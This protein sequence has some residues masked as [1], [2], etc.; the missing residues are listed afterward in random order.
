MFPLHCNSCFC[1]QKFEPNR[2]FHVSRCG[3]I[4]CK[5]CLQPNCP[6]CSKPY[7]AIEI[8]KDM[9]PAMVQYFDDP[10]KHYRHYQNIM[11]FHY[12]Q[13]AML[14][15]HMTTS[16]DAQIKKLEGE[17]KAFARIQ[18]TLDDKL[19]Q[20]RNRIRKLKEYIA[21]HE[22]R[23]EMAPPT[24][25][26]ITAQP[27]FRYPSSR[28]KTSSDEGKSKSR[29]CLDFMPQLT[30]TIRAHYAPPRSPTLSNPNSS[31][32]E[33]TIGHSS[34]NKMRSQPSP[35]PPMTEHK[36]KSKADVSYL[37]F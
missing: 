11:K 5:E 21:Y 15:D 19:E 9:P 35:L 7:N 29:E 20:E 1:R 28:H 10:I 37:K 26:S 31:E 32:S 36:K 34:L 25:P 23:M 33:K 30:Q 2:K 8:R 14:T 18:K 24:T 22:R 6:L 17:L 4:I 27:K 16:Q 12:E 3:H 13:E